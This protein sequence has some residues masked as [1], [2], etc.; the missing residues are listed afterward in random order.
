LAALSLK[1]SLQ[2]AKKLYS[3]KDISDIRFSYV[4]EREDFGLSRMLPIHSDLFVSYSRTSHILGSAL[5]TIGWLNDKDER[6]SMT[7][8]GDLGNNT[9]ENPYQPLLAGRQGVKGYPAAIVVEST[10]GGRVRDNKF[11]DFDGRMTAL[12]RV[13]QE[14]VFAKKGQLIIPAFSLQRTQEILIDLFHVFKSSFATDESSQSPYC[15]VNPAYGDFIDDSWSNALQ[16]SL[17]TILDTF[18]EAEKA[19]WVDSIEKKDKMFSLKENAEV[20]LDELKELV[21]SSRHTYPVDIVLDSPL[22]KAMGDVFREELCRRQRKD[23]EKPLYRNR[24][25]MERLGLSDE[26]HVDRFIKSLFPLDDDKPFEFPIGIHKIR[27]EHGFT[28]PTLA[29]SRKRGCIVITGG[30]MCE[31]GPVINHLEKIAASKRPSAILVTGY[32]A[33]GTLGDRLISLSN[34]RDQGEPLPFEKLVVGEKEIPAQDFKA[35][36]IPFQSYYSGHADQ[37]GL[38]DFVFKV[39]GDEPDGEPRK[40]TTVFLNHGQHLSRN[41]LKVSVEARA[42]ELKEGDRCI[43][44]VELPDDSGQW[45]DLNNR[46]WIEPE[47]ETKSERLLRELLFEQRKTNNLLLRLAEQ[48][49]ANYESM[50]KP[51]SKKN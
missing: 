15:V 4:D 46:Q 18:S 36:I 6:L 23:P 8:S 34:A 41:T 20:S 17:L 25:L 32:M 28:L 7:M 10:Y 48:K 44:S 35:K 38:L 24:M 22:A 2:Y 50:K 51:K 5:I 12:Q 11:S 47:H 42:K 39:F 14:E 45:Y 29:E 1:D 9:K 31:G 40:T 13:V 27:Y 16:N 43:A 49:S 26:S 19:R 33:K 21:E 3:E 37:S 30:G